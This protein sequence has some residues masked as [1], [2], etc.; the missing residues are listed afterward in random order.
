MCQMLRESKKLWLLPIVT[1]LFAFGALVAA[2]GTAAA[3]FI[4]SLF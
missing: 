4:Y 2:S 1:A 3:P